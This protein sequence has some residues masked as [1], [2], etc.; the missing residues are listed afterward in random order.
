[1][2][3]HVAAALY[4]A[5]APLDFVVCCDPDGEVG[6]ELATADRRCLQCLER[7]SDQR[8][9]R[10]TPAFASGH[11]DCP[12]VDVPLTP[13]GDL[14]RAAA[15]SDGGGDAPRLVLTIAP[16]RS[17]LPRPDLVLRDVAITPSPPSPVVRH[18]RSVVLVV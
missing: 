18:L 2:W 1:M 7:E 17:L 13:D 11:R 14:A 3:F 8:E 15:K 10:D 16:A 9:P 4:L 12:C 5:L 6:L